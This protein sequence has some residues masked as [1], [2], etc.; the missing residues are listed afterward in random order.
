MVSEQSGSIA[1]PVYLPVGILEFVVVGVT[2]QVLSVTAISDT[3]HLKSCWM[4]DTC[5]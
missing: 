2:L 4:F 3:Q 5:W 1:D